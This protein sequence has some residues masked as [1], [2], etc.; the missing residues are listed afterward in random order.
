MSDIDDI[1]DTSVISDI[2]HFSDTHVTGEND[3]ITSVT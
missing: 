1:S 3:I 2:N